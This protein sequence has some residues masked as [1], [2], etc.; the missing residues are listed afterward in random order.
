MLLHIAFF[1][2]FLL[3][4]VC[5]IPQL[6]VLVYTMCIF[7]VVLLI[8]CL[9]L[10]RIQKLSG[11]TAFCFFTKADGKN[12]LTHLESVSAVSFARMIIIELLE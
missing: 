4:R 11:M 12:I 3:M 9:D 10:L 6:L 5:L 7:Q 8:H 1:F 2:L